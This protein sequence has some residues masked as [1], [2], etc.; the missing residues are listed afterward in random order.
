[1]KKIQFTFLL[2]ICAI[3]SIAFAAETDP[4]FAASRA[5]AV[6][7]M[8]G[9]SNLVASA[10]TYRDSVRVVADGARGVTNRVSI[11]PRPGAASSG[12]FE[13]A[14]PSEVALVQLYGNV[15]LAS[16]ATN[17]LSGV[18]VTALGGTNGVAVAVATN[19]VSSAAFAGR[20]LSTPATGTRLVIEAAAATA[21]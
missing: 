4:L 13:L 6:F 10:G 2:A 12:V 15:T 3:A 16:G 5:D 8:G 21:R 9:N 19:T 11:L 7:Q 14:I 1:M 20:W 18:T 17:G